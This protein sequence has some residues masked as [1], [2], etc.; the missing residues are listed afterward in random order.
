MMWLLSVV[1][2]IKSRVV[3]IAT[4]FAAAIALVLT[5]RKSGQHAER[6]KELEEV[7]KNVRKKDGATEKVD[8]MPDGDAARRLR[9]T[10]SR[11]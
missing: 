2:W 7:L 1:G 11:D 9:D 10:W 6:V 4:F 5:A 8:R 3:G